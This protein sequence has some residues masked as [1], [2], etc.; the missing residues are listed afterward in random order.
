MPILFPARNLLYQTLLTKM[1]SCIEYMNTF[2]L[3]K[4]FPTGRSLQHSLRPL[5]VFRG[6]TSKGRRGEGRKGIYQ[7][8]AP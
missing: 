5:A 8:D 1:Y 4:R 2:W 3:K 7:D 6:P